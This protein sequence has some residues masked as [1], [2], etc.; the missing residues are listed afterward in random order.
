M[1]TTLKTNKKLSLN[2][3]SSSLISFHF[4]LDMKSNKLLEDFMINNKNFIKI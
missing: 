2:L 4:E 3:H 1:F